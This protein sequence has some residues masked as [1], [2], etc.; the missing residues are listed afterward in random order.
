MNN[1]TPA[2]AVLAPQGLLNEAIN[3]YEKGDR[4]VAYKL[5][6]DLTYV[7][8][9]S[10][11]QH[12]ELFYKVIDFLSKNKEDEQTSRYIQDILNFL[13][14]VQKESSMEKPLTEKQEM[15]SKI[16]PSMIKDLTERLSW[17][18]FDR[19]SKKSV[20]EGS[21]KQKIFIETPNP[22]PDKTLKGRKQPVISEELQSIEKSI[23]SSIHGTPDKPVTIDTLGNKIYA[24]GI[25][26]FLTHPKT[27]PPL[28]I[29]IQ[30][31][32][33][34]GK[35]SIMRMIQKEIDP[36]AADLENEN[37]TTREQSVTVGQVRSVLEKHSNKESIKEKHSNEE[38]IKEKHSIEE[39]FIIED[40]PTMLTIWFNVWKYQN[41]EQIWAGLA[42]TIITQFSK[43]L[44]PE[45][46]QK[47]FMELDSR[48]FGKDKILR[49]IN[50]R[51][52]NLWIEKIRT[53]WWMGLTGIGSSAIWFFLDAIKWTETFQSYGELYTVLLG[54]GGAAFIG[55]QRNEA[56]Q[57]VNKEDSSEVLKESVQPPDYSANL[58]FIHHVDA[59]MRRVLSIIKKQNLKLLVFIDDLDRCSPTKVAEVFEGINMFISAEYSNCFFVIGMD[60]EIVAAALEKAHSEIIQKMP[61]YSRKAAIGWRFMDKFVQMPIIIP[62][63][64]PS[65]VKAYVNSLIT[66][67]ESNSEQFEI[68]KDLVDKGNI[69]DKIISDPQ[70]FAEFVKTNFNKEVK[71]DDHNIIV[72]QYHIV[73]AQQKTTDVSSNITKAG[74][75]YSDK[76]PEVQDQITKAVIE[77]SNNPRE[78]KRFLNAL[79][80]N[81]FLRDAKILSKKKWPDIRVPTPDQVRRWIILTMKWPQF[82]LWLHRSSGG[83]AFDKSSKNKT[84]E[85]LKNVEDY[86]KNSFDEWQEK[87]KKLLQVDSKNDEDNI[88][89]INDDNL[90]KFFQEESG[91]LS[92][93]YGTGLY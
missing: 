75:D 4:Q 48:R 60:I 51:I 18:E 62:P 17:I 80:F 67:L 87:L 79:R 24:T 38:S 42:D 9:Q 86:S 69:D 15:I 31:P 10:F 47:F 12:I 76:N 61:A 73:I 5:F 3:H 88:S 70:K 92:E 35:T 44:S 19:K 40:K 68:A 52:F 81:F 71:P 1:H 91:K 65:N 82:A 89:W 53:K 32:W 37:Q 66:P 85:I 41:T 78:M 11:P 46:E 22:P 34:G 54:L 58:G 13:H 90:Q 36:K 16:A 83:I 59:D 74:D 7:L 28:T 30:A 56:A 20:S 14:S 72:N 57:D 23:R 25:Y 26:A 45:N 29:S 27:E 43:R 55:I 33:G 50:K 93:A 63:P 21:R 84:M 2:M 49:K 77:F 64:S 39:K 6:D 8:Q